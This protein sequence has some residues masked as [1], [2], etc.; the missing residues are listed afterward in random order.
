MTRSLLCIDAE[1]ALYV[2]EGMEKKDELEMSE[3]AVNEERTYH[4]GGHDVIQ[5]GEDED[6]VF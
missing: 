4:F 2:R 6:T 3:I 5:V 1:L